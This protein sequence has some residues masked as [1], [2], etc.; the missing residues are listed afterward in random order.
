MTTPFSSGPAP[1]EKADPEIEKL[2]TELQSALQAYIVSLLGST[3]GLGDVLQETNIV[4]WE[5]RSQFQ[6][7]TNFKAW[8]FRIAYFKAL[9]FRRDEAKRGKHQF[10]EQLLVKIA[11]ESQEFNGRSANLRA[12]ALSQCLDSLPEPQ[13]ILV[14]EHYLDGVSLKDLAERGGRKAPAVHKE[15]SRLRLALRSCVQKRLNRPSI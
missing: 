12:E 1:E 8:A 5:K 6:K 13:K 10:N 7:G 15:I 2:L 14:N 4:I 11:T 3:S 9:G